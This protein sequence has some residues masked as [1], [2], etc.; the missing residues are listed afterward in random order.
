MGG[1]G[2]GKKINLSMC[3]SVNVSNRK[4]CDRVKEFA[5]VYKPTRP[6]IKDDSCFERDMIRGKSS[7]FFRFKFLFLQNAII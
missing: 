1:G 5:T 2:T 3:D 4:R 7:N 6:R